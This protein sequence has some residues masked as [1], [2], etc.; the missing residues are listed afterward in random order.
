MAEQQQQKQGELN[1]PNR[2]K[3]VRRRTGWQVAGVVGL[4]VS[5]WPVYAE[6]A[7]DSPAAPTRRTAAEIDWRPAAQLPDDRRKALPEYCAG[8]YITPESVPVDLSVPQTDLPVNVQ[9][10]E[11]YWE[12]GRTLQVTGDVKL[13]QGNYVAEVDKA[14]L[15]LVSG[16][17]D[18]QGQVEFRGPGFFMTGEEARYH[19]GSGK[20]ELDEASFLLHESEIRGEAR[21]I[22]RPEAEQLII[23]KGE[24][25]TCDPTDNAWSIRAKRVKLDK[26]E[27]EGRARNVTFRV[28][29]VPVFY[30]PWFSFPIDDRRKSGFLYPEFGS[31]NVGRGIYVATPYYFNLAPHYDATLTPQYIH[32]RGIHNELEGR[33]LSPFGQSSLAL[34]YIAKDDEFELENPDKDGERWAVDLES[35]SRWSRQWSTSIDY[36]QISDNDYLSD[37]NNSL[38]IDQTT[39]LDRQIRTDYVGET[40]QFNTIVHGYQTIDSTILDADKPYQRL[41]EINLLGSWTGDTLAWRWDSQYVY[42]QRESEKLTGLSRTNGSRLR[43]QPKVSMPLENDYSFFTPAIRIDHTDYA[44]E[45]YDLGKNHQSRTVPFYSVDSGLYFDRPFEMN[46]LAFNQTLEPRLF[47][48]YSKAENQDDLP[49][50]DSSLKSFSFSQ[51]FS[52]DRFNGGDRV[53]DNHRLT[54]ALTTRFTED[55]RGIDRA[56]FSVGQIYYFEDREVGINGEGASTRSDSQLAGEMI[57]RPYDWMDVFV[58]GLWDAR[59]KETDEGSTRMSLHSTDYAWVLSM[60]H[61]F[62]DDINVDDRIEQTDVSSII[63]VTNQISL[64]GRWL[65]DLND[66]R[67]MGTMAGLEYRG[68]CWRAQLMSH[69]KLQD[70]THLDHGFMFRFELKGLGGTGASVKEIDKEIPGYDAHHNQWHGVRR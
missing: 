35:R 48:V 44:L 62:K 30:F 51:L 32:G 58:T 47:Y 70:D 17:S 8:A 65:Y 50:F 45:D 69:S 53:G 18:L 9:A 29:D 11:A 21:H 31:S 55:T 1:A 49:N 57:L 15:D 33:Y 13:R 43:H 41:P 38:S 5:V 2:T 28:K 3:N 40:W 22:R 6:T 42:F 67:T 56:V 66:E 12:D 37:L 23:E 14:N 10:D 24:F 34:G 27:G 25:T 59:E 60:G 68:C 52:D 7:S 54:A 61:R 26:A 39:H 16:V 46:Q 63:P 64:F 20:F 4:V 36:S 19:Q